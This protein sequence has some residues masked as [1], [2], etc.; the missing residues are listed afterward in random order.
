MLVAAAVPYSNA[1]ATLSYIR[2]KSEQGCHLPAPPKLLSSDYSLTGLLYVPFVYVGFHW[3]L[4]IF[5]LL[6]LAIVPR[7]V[8]NRHPSAWFYW[9]RPQ[10]PIILTRTKP[11]PNVNSY[12]V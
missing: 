6:L 5:L 10:S 9:D 8:T 12:T 1:V 4:H 7:M 2:L 11:G 3:V